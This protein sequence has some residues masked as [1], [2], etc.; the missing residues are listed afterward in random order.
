MYESKYCAPIPRAHFIRR[1]LI[2]FLAAIGL[3]AASLLVGM[4]GYE[5]FEHLAWRDA[6]INSAMLLGGMGP[7]N[8]PQSDGGKVFAGI[9]ALYAGLVFLIVLAIVLT[10]VIHRVLHTFHWEVDD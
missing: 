4:V 6:F 9:Y 7:V 8:A 3:L 5:H 2:H 10:P 1:L